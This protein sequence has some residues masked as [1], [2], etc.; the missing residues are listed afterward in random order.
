MI[1]EYM[2]KIISK[3][4]GSRPCD[5]VVDVD[6]MDRWYVIP[7]NRFFNVYAHRFVG[8]DAPVPHDH[9]W[10]SL[11]WILKGNY[12]EHT[13]YGSSVKHSGSVTIRGPKSL[14]WIEI[15]KP[16]WT[17]FITGPKIRDW[18]FLCNAIWINHTDYINQRG[19]DRLASGC[20]ETK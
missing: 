12:T 4:M 6:Y 18:G 2:R 15:D 17:L 13:P 5:L 9:P 19:P 11:S 3:L 7:R 20:G 10:A 16:V 14:H 8:S 1:T